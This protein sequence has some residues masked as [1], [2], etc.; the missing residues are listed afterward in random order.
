MG[1]LSSE[2]FLELAWA[3][4]PTWK[5]G[6]QHWG[7]TGRGG[8]GFEQCHLAGRGFP[9]FPLGQPRSKETG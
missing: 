2:A 1:L 7:S 3:A 4:A 6:H 8:K 5:A 9:G